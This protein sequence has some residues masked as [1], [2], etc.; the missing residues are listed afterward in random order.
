M[1]NS[2]LLSTFDYAPPDAVRRTEAARK[3]KGRKEIVAWAFERPSGGRSFGFTGG[4]T[5]KNWANDDFHRLVVNAILWSAGVEIPSDGAKAR[6]F[7]PE[8]IKRNLDR[9]PRR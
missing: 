7:D 8:D 3:H 4:H 2:G 6:M 9:K 5:H 1:A